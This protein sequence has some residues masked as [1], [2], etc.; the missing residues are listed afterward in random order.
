M[1]LLAAA[2][3]VPSTAAHGAALVVGAFLLSCA[4]CG[5][6]AWRAHRL[7]SAS[8]ANRAE[9]NRHA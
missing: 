7:N 2:I 1:P 9:E 4:F 5:I 3:V 6:A 8:G